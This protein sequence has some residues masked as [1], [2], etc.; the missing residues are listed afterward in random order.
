MP[1]QKGCF[2]DIGHD[3]LLARLPTFTT[4]LRRRLKA[5]TVEPGTWTPTTTGSPQGGIAS[6]SL[7]DVALDGMERLCGAEDVHGRPVRPS[8]RRGLDRGAGP[9]RHADDLVVTAPTREVLETYVVPTP[10]R[11]RE[12]RGLGLS[13][14]K[15]RIVHIDEGFD[16]LGFTVRRY[17]GVVLTAPRKAKVVCGTCAPSATT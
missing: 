2:D 8:H 15:T 7:A 6:P 1:G 9:V 16:F 12:G 13:A 17:R 10:T 4:I 5:G 3:P 11:F 14:K